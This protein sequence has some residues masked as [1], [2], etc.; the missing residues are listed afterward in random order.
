MTDTPVIRQTLKDDWDRHPNGRCFVVVD[1]TRESG[2][3]RVGTTG[4][5]RHVQPMTA[6]LKT[7]EAL[8]Q[9]ELRVLS[10]P[11]SIGCEPYSL[12]M[13]AEEAGIYARRTL[14]IDGLDISPLFITAAREAVYM[15]EMIPASLQPQFRRHFHAAA[16]GMVAVDDALKNRVNFMDAQDLTALRPEKPYDA[17]V[18]LNLLIQINEKEL[19]QSIAETIA[20]LSPAALLMN[21]IHLVKRVDGAVNVVRYEHWGVIE[22]VLCDGGYVTAYTQFGELAGLSLSPRKLQNAVPYKDDA[23][24]LF[25]KKQPRI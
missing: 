18:M 1:D 9:G 14:V 13:L 12:A 22:D 8:P 2:R 11:C 17:L 5:M 15:P 24:F 23:T 16:D 19:A 20:R 10:A 3:K 4:F 21:N 6:L 25:V 7:L